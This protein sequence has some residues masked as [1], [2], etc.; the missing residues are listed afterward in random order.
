M[1]HL[2]M[3]KAKISVSHGAGGRMMQELIKEIASIIENKKTRDGRGIDVLEDAGIAN[4]NG[5]KI[6]FT[7]DS[8]TVDPIFFP[9]GS[10]GK[11]AVCGTINDLAVMGA[12]P[13]ALTLALVLEEGFPMAELKKIVMD[14][15]KEVKKANVA[16]ISGDTK[17]MEKG[18]IDKIIIN[19]AG[20]GIVRY[21]VSDYYARPGDKVIVSGSIGDHG[22]AL[23]AR[24]FKFETKLKSDCSS[25]ASMALS[26]LKTGGIRVMKDP[27]RGGLAAC[28]NEI[29]E[30]SKVDMVVYEDKVPIKEEVRSVG[31]VLGIDPMHT[32]CEGRCVIIAKEEKAEEILNMAKRFDRNA[33]IIGDVVK[34]SGKVFIETKI[35]S[36]RYL[37]S[38]IG[39]LYPRI[40]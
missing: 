28:L 7:T 5:T 32:A 12:K 36:K 18:K 9:G 39:E 26:L 19:T 13:L 2:D 14:I 17:V 21:D 1:L 30:K 3:D 10:I 35:G 31:E 20:I 38:P 34:G 37:E 6:A 25:I 22:M 8:Y 40:C 27:T 23:L 11:L 24:R 33:S 29:A 16:I 4:I 15:N